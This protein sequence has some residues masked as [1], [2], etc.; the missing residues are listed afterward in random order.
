MDWEDFKRLYQK[1]SNGEE[2]MAQFRD[3]LRRKCLFDADRILYTCNRIVNEELLQLKQDKPYSKE[4][5]QTLSTERCTK[6]YFDYY[7]QCYTKL[8]K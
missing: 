2:S 3:R 8:Y 7:T 5:L 1:E 6:E 4:Y